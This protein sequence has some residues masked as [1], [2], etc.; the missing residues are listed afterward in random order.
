MRY[1]NPASLD[2]I[3]VDRRQHSAARTVNCRF[4]GKGEPKIKLIAAINGF[5]KG[6]QFSALHA[7]TADG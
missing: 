5:L 7:W 4:A 6:D 3:D 2:L 1:H